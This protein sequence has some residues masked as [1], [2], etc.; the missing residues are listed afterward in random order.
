[1]D[2]KWEKKIQRA[3]GCEDI[4]FAGHPSEIDQAVKLLKEANKQGMGFKDYC[5]SI[6]A[7]LQNHPKKLGRA[8]IKKQMKKVR[9]LES[10]FQAS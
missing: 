9:S 5:Q 3:F 2:S 7:W 10:Y 1:M 4:E 8:F 6:N